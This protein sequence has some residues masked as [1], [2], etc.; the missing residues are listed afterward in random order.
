M[1]GEYY[2]HIHMSASDE[3]G[4]TLGGHLNE[5]RISAICQMF[6][7]IIDGIV[8]RYKDEQTGLNLFKFD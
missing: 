7:Y 5:A 1:N 2:S 3:T 4:R 8:D 6:I